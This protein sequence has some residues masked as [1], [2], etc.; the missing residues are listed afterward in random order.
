MSGNT[1]LV[2]AKIARDDEYYTRLEDIACEM[3]Y[4][5]DA[6]CGKHVYLPCDHPDHSQ[7]WCYFID[8]ANVL[9]WTTLTATCLSRDGCGVL[10]RATQNDDG[11]TIEISKLS[12]NGDFLSDE[13][14]SFLAS[15]DIVVTNLPFSQFR[16]YVK[17]M[18]ERDK[19]FIVIGSKNGGKYQDT[20]GY[21]VDGRMRLGGNDGR[22]SMIF[23]TADGG[24]ASVGSYWY[25]T[26]KPN[27]PRRKITSDHLY[28]GH[29]EDYPKYS[30]YDA[31]EVSKMS[32]LPK[33]YTGKMGVPITFLEYYDEDEWI[34]Y[35]TNATVLENAPQD[36]E[37]KAN[38]HLYRRHNLYIEEEG[39]AYKYRRIYDRLIIQR[40]SR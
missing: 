7:F 18:M 39:G 12:G 26:L 25:T 10:A 30:N 3:S 38:S 5:P 4:Y 16:A 14:L 24:S 40:K 27:K 37:I 35:G 34:L 15:C 6:F 21:I 13:C 17:A 8:N 9:G 28:V 36:P 11:I 31:I 22:G 2:S 29:E 1:N 19:D 23:D 33:D 32:M 20:V